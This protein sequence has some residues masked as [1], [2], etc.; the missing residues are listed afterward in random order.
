MFGDFLPFFGIPIRILLNVVGIS[1]NP[2]SYLQYYNPKIIYEEDKMREE[3]ELE[4]IQ[5]SIRELFVTWYKQGKQ[6]QHEK[7]LKFTNYDILY[8][9]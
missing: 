5:T 9:V 6:I 2:D 8:F 7:W 4:Q 1:I 3:N